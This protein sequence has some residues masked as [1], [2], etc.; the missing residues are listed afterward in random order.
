MDI[1]S[2]SYRAINLEHAIELKNIRGCLKRNTTMF[3][4]ASQ[5]VEPRFMDSFSGAVVRRP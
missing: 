2:V 4:S 3:I 5:Y 1:E